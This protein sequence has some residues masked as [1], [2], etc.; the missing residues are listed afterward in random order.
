ME[1]RFNKI[2]DIPYSYIMIGFKHG[3]N[4]VV[5]KIQQSIINKDTKENHNFID[6]FD[7][8]TKEFILQL[9]KY[10]RNKIDIE[11]PDFSALEI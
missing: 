8:E 7:K 1:G 4:T 2:M 9:Q 3:Q 5:K 11:I 6:D 10:I